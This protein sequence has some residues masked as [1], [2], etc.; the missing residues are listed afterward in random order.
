MAAVRKVNQAEDVRAVALELFAEHGYRGTGIR[1]IAKVLGLRPTSVYS[2]IQSKQELLRDIVLGA[3]T[4]VAALQEDAIATSADPLEQLRR[5]AEAHVR[6]VTRC[7]R[8]ALV[9]TQEF[10]G[11]EEPALAEVLELREQIQRTVQDVIERGVETGVLATEDPKIAS[12]A[13]IE[14]CEGV[15]RWFRESGVLSEARLSSM[16][17]E[18][19]VRLAGGCR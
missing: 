8:E 19:A 13:I 14:M 6:Y 3:C 10:G 12:F 1:D 9:T 2:H 16:Y 17:G 15:A 18:F 11:V 7:P 5:A 4:T